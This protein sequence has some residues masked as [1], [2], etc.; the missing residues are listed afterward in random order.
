MV[1][2][3]IREPSALNV[4]YSK[5]YMEHIEELSRIMFGFHLVPYNLQLIS[6]VMRYSIG[7]TIG[8]D[9]LPRQRDFHKEV[10]K[11]CM[12]DEQRVLPLVIR[13]MVSSGCAIEFFITPD[14]PA[15]H[16]VFSTYINNAWWAWALE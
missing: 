10:A 15:Y 2:I 9:A 1:K 7:E 5:A 3:V 6:R 14:E 8:K 4:I 16:I 11:Y 13:E 12:E